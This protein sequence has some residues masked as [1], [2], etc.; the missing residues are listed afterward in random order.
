MARLPF[1]HVLGTVAD[2]PA[3][4]KRATLGKAIA[5]ALLVS[6]TVFTV[7]PPGAVALAAPASGGGTTISAVRVSTVPSKAG[8]LGIPGQAATGTSGQAAT[9]A[10]SG[11]TTQSTVE[12]MN[13]AVTGSTLDLTGSAIQANGTVIP[14]NLTGGLYR[15]LAPSRIDGDLRDAT[16]NFDVMRFQIDES[17]VHGIFASSAAR[18]SG[19]PFLAL[20]IERTGT[21]DVTFVE[22]PAAQILGQDTLGRLLA[23]GPQL[24]LAPA[25]ARL[26]EERLFTSDSVDHVVRSTPLP[27]TEPVRPMTIH[28]NFTSTTSL[29]P[30]W[31]ANYYIFGYTVVDEMEIEEYVTYPN[32][33]AGQAII[34]QIDPYWVD[35]K[36]SNGT[37]L[38]QSGFEIG[39]GGPAGVKLTCQNNSS[40]RIQWESIAGQVNQSSS[41]SV[42]WAISLSFKDFGGPGLQYNPSGS[43]NISGGGNVS[44]QN[45]YLMDVYTNSGQ[46]MNYAGPSNGNHGGHDY[47]A[48]NWEAPAAAGSPMNVTDEVDFVVE[49][50]NDLQRASYGTETD[51]VGFT[52]YAG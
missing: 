50:Y 25:S 7:A 4:L 13:A 22:A 5:T 41:V 19:Q 35:F 1:A 23:S 20:Y 51:P 31:T 29:Y 18:A 8:D 24:G 52:T 12:V 16:G 46:Y 37:D 38:Y 40:Q 27:G 42:V 33:T 11:S 6:T 15:D 48:A 21:R 3:I 45:S 44:G 26:W 30:V 2:G 32:T 39:G 47:L 34:A 9:S 43:V 10:V 36:E 28:P 17:P 49:M 14:F